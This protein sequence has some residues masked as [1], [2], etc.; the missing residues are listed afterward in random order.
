MVL[1][2]E[3]LSFSVQA[4]Q[5]FIIYTDGKVPFS[6]AEWKSKRMPTKRMKV[7][8]ELVNGVVVSVKPRDEVAAE[9][10]VART[11]EIPRQAANL[12]VY[13]AEQEDVTG[14]VFSKIMRG[15]GL[16]AGVAVIIFFAIVLR[17]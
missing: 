4:N 2:G 16:L 13:A 15:L 12:P 10:T 7:R 17:T 5:G 8:A 3:L 1:D 14:R 11:V 6:G 9:S